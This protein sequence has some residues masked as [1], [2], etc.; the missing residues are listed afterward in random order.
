[1][2][3]SLSHAAIDE[4]RLNLR[5]PSSLQDGGAYQ[6]NFSQS[7]EASVIE[8]SIEDTVL[9]SI[10]DG[11]KYGLDA[12]KY[13]TTTTGNSYYGFGVWKPDEY[14][15]LSLK[16]SSTEDWILNHGLNFS[17]ST[18]SN[19]SDARYRFDMRWHEDTNTEI[20]LQMQVPIQ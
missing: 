3:A 13:L 19:I 15:G 1:M 6:I 20:L 4:T 5:S 17:F 10:W 14:Q 12:P 9:P 8:W 7:Y 18:D 2:T 11:W 16:D